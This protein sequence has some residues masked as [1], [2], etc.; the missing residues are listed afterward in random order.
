M[1]DAAVSKYGW[2]KVSPSEAMPGDL[3]VDIGVHA[4]IYAGNGEI[5]DEQAAITC[6]GKPPTKSKRKRS[7][8][9]CRVWRA[10]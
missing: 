2:K 6:N 8:E 1:F 7:I 4:M 3:V 5:W 9:G 10:P